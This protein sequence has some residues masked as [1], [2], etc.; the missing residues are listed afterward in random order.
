MGREG[1]TL[2]KRA[3]LMIVAVMALMLTGSVAAGVTLPGPHRMACP[4][5]YGLVH[6]GNDVF[7]DP[8]M[9]QRERRSALRSIDRGRQVV[10]AFYGS[11][12]S[13]PRIV[14]CWTRSCS[15]IFGSRGAKGVTY[16]WHAILLSRS[17]ILDV[18][19][20]H[21]IAHTELHW[22]MGY[23]GW[24]RGTVPVWFDEGL[25]VIVS[26]DPRFRR[27]VSR[28][29]VSEIV[30]VTSYMGQWSDHARRVGWRTAYGAAA[31]RV[32]QIERL[33]GRHRLRA[34]ALRL[35]SEGNFDALLA[36]ARSKGRN[37]R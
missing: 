21:E 12:K 17:R 22:R 30:R 29:A 20:A 5:C 7:A 18:I 35:A 25:A 2:S 4:Q 15:S 16:A 23:S 36:Q 11:L 37:F 34:F 10:R 3:R 8:V 33:L 32:R 14:V 1:K 13:S 6:I 27:D 26:A 28:A 19:A 9:T 24:L 31:T